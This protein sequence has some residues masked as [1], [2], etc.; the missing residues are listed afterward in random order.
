MND[1]FDST[2]FTLESY[3]PEQQGCSIVPG[4]NAFIDEVNTAF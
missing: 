1:V 4:T 3:K 2:G